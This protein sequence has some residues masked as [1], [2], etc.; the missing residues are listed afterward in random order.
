MLTKEAT[1]TDL[2]QKI[3]EVLSDLLKIN[4]EQSKAIGISYERLWQEL[5]RLVLSG[6]KENSPKNNA[7]NIQS[8]W[9]K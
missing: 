5:E 8:I 9:R 3:D 7:S 1:K 4:I 6:G 2:S